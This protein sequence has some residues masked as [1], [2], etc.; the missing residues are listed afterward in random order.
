MLSCITD[1]TIFSLFA[2]QPVIDTHQLPLLS[3]DFV[4][5]HDILW[6]ADRWQMN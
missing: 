2:K 5:L 4:Y 6:K 1:K 3:T